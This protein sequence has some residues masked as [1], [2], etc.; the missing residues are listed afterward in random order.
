MK[1]LINLTLYTPKEPDVP[2]ALY[3][4]D[5]DG[6]DWYEA[7]KDFQEDTLKIQF[8]AQGIITSMSQDVSALW[9]VEQSV[10][11]VV[12]ADIPKGLDIH[13]GW[14]FDGNKISARVLPPE[15]LQAQVAA[16]KQQLMTQALMAMLPLEKAVKLNV[17]TEE[18]KAQLDLWEKYC[19]LLGRV[20]LVKAPKVKWPKPPA[21]P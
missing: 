2:G 11:E 14:V 7:Q 10:T 17:A 16:Q 19:V 5:E 12:I 1:T 21:H 3:L 20:E 6:Q 8:N 9:P 15:E 18:E 4:Q 13:G